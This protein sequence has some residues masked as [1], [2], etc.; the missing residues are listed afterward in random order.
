MALPLPTLADEDPLRMQLQTKVQACDRA[1]FR[2]KIPLIFPKIQLIVPTE[3]WA[4]PG[5][6]FLFLFF[7]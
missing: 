2:T 1:W 3:G 6:L 4:T 7:N 5:T